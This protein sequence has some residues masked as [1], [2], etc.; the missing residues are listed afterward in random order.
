[1]QVSFS[2]PFYVCVS[3]QSKVNVSLVSHS[4]LCVY[5][6]HKKSH[7]LVSLL[8]S[9]FHSIAKNV[10]YKISLQVPKIQF[11]LFIVHSAPLT[12]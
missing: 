8:H 6:V 5:M 3:M 7:C 10:L 4:A 12:C 11:P 1:M 9:G 2:L